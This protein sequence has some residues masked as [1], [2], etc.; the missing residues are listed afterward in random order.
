MKNVVRSL[1]WLGL[2]LVSRLGKLLLTWLGSVFAGL[3]LCKLRVGATC[4]G[5]LMLALSDVVS[6]AEDVTGFRGFAWGT[7]FEV[8]N[9]EKELTWYQNVGD[10]GEHLSL[11][12]TVTDE[13]GGVEIG[14]SYRFY[15][16]SW[17]WE[18]LLLRSE[19]II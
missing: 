12:D 10:T 15:Q 18:R 2:G 7:D 3:S 8:V 11:L 6:A 19:P 9:R 14:Y 17:W 13:A 5:L 16:N 4:V 1:F